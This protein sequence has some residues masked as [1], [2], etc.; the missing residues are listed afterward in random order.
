MRLTLLPLLV[1][2]SCSN[3]ISARMNEKVLAYYKAINLAEIAICDS[4]LT[5]ANKYYKEAF[6]IN[7]QKPFSRDLLNAF[8]A[9][10]DTREYALAETYL[11]KVLSRGIDTAIID[12]SFYRY[13]TGEDLKRLKAMFTRHPNKDLSK[14]PLGIELNKMLRWDRDVRMHFAALYDGAYMVDSTYYVD[15][16][17][18]K[19]LL[20]MFRKNGVPNEDIIGNGRSDLRPI[21]TPGFTIIISHALAGEERY[22]H[23]PFDTLLFDAVNSFDF[24]LRIY[25]RLIGGN[26]ITGNFRYKDLTLNFPLLID[27]GLYQGNVY[28]EYWDDVSEEMIDA[29]RAKIGL[30]PLEDFRKKMA[31]YNRGKDDL[32][33]KYD[34][35]RN[36]RLLAISIEERF[37]KFLLANT[38]G[39]NYNGSLAEARKRQ[40]N[41]GVDFGCTYDRTIGKTNI[42]SI[43]LQYPIGDWLKRPIPYQNWENRRSPLK[44][45]QHAEMVRNPVSDISSDIGRYAQARFLPG[46][47]LYCAAYSYDYGAIDFRNEE[48]IF[49]NNLLISYTADVD[50]GFYRYK[51]VVNKIGHPVVNVRTDT[52]K[53]GTNRT[54]KIKRYTW[55]KGNNRTELTVS[56]YYDK[57]NRKRIRSV[58]Q[59]TDVRRYTVYLEKVDAEK[60]RLEKEYLAGKENS[61]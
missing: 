13:Y 12:S 40:R 47:R 58:Y 2:L 8:Y 18:S 5:E 16:V 46:Y 51:T 49:E 44:W 23:L 30:E 11:T 7:R 14:T 4:N 32:L 3:A 26:K 57:E 29:E 43:Y 28:P 24:D 27:G 22:G 59:M 33:G 34:L 31:T 6:T 17:N 41:S 21:G 19:K 56:E 20:G 61:K 10:M 52:L 45:G 1:L 54:L 39:G 53:D 50:S 9:A 38:K 35:L 48:S 42:D 25:A 15:N 55:K 60:K 37:Q 36:I